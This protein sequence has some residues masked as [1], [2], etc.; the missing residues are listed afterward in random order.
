MRSLSKE[1]ARE[2][3]KNTATTEDQK[4]GYYGEGYADAVIYTCSELT[5][6]FEDYLLSAE[7]CEKIKSLK[8]KT[9]IDFASLLFRVIAKEIIDNYKNE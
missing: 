8:Y 6:R 7:N 4:C 3:T 9:D 2:Y 1:E 5:K